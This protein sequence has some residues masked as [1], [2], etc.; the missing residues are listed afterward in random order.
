MNVVTPA[1]AKTIHFTD[2]GQDFLEWDVS[3]EG[4]VLDVRPFQGWLW[5]G[6]KVTNMA[7]LAPDGIVQFTRP[8]DGDKTLTVK[9]PVVEIEVKA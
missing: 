3:A 1:V 4:L 2:N 8:G 5:K 9:Y 7:D 6:C